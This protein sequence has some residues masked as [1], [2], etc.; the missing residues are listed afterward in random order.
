MLLR[1]VV[2]VA[3]PSKVRNISRTAPA[4]KNRAKMPIIGPGNWSA[5]L[6]RRKKP[7]NH[8]SNSHYAERLESLE[9]LKVNP[10]KTEQSSF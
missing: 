10:C 2:L 5:S 1:G 9:T 6:K 8:T 4:V 7:F 3:P